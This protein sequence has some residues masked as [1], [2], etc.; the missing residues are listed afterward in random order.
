MHACGT[1]LTREPRRS[2]PLPA[3]MVR[4]RACAR[5]AHTSS[6]PHRAQA[7]LLLCC[8]QLPCVPAPPV[9]LQVTRGTWAYSLLLSSSQMARFAAP[10]CFN[11]LHVIRMDIVGIDGQVGMQRAVARPPSHGLQVECHG[12]LCQLQP[13]FCTARAPDCS[14][15]AWNPFILRHNCALHTCLL[16]CSPVRALACSPA[17]QSGCLCR[18]VRRSWCFS[19]RWAP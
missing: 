15:R 17:R 1:K 6:H 4:T 2:A 8:F 3:G 7:W 13:A 16:V 5:A 9:A 10:L 18:R 19:R 11:F 14:T 12:R